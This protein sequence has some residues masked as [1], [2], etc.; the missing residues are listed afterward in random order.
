MSWSLDNLTIPPDAQR[1]TISA[2]DIHGLASQLQLIVG[3]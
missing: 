1:L 2:E 3:R